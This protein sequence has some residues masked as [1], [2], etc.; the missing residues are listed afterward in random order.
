MVSHRNPN[1]LPPRG[2]DDLQA[3]GDLAP[4]AIYGFFFPSVFPLGE[5]YFSTVVSPCINPPTTPL[6]ILSPPP[7]NRHTHALAGRH[8]GFK[9]RPLCPP[10]AA[11]T[12]PAPALARQGRVF[13]GSQRP[14]LLSISY[15][16]PP[17]F[18]ADSSG[19]AGEMGSV[20]SEGACPLSSPPSRLLSPHKKYLSQQGFLR[21]PPAPIL[22]S[23][24]ARRDMHVQG[25]AAL[26]DAKLRDAKH[27]V[28]GTPGRAGVPRYRVINISACF[29]LPLLHPGLWFQIPPRPTHTCLSARQ[30]KRNIL[31]LPAFPT[32][33]GFLEGGGMGQG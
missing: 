29:F 5:T 8:K 21:P 2:A 23:V 33:A 22:P 9:S 25:C 10:T 30:D 15:G 6:S 32:Q 26:R 17:G 13:F 27:A 31:F 28:K 1:L 11:L 18:K 20:G 14:P 19:K 4:C 3:R 24:H 12:A 7:Q 16:T